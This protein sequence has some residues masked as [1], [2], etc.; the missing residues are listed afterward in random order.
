MADFFGFS[1]IHVTEFKNLLPK[2]DFTERD[3]LKIVSNPV[4]SSGKAA[5]APIEDFTNGLYLEGAKMN[6]FRMHPKNV[7]KWVELLVVRYHQQFGNSKQYECH[8]QNKEEDNSNL[9]D[10]IQ[11]Q[12]N[13]ISES[14]TLKL[15]T[16]KVYL[17]THT[18]TIQGNY[19]EQWCKNEFCWMKQLINSC[20]SDELSHEQ[21]KVDLTSIEDEF[22]G[23][24]NG[25]TLLKLPVSIEDEFGGDLNDTTLLKLPVQSANVICETITKDI[26]NDDTNNNVTAIQSNKNDKHE[27]L[28]S[29]SDTIKTIHTS[30]Q[31][32]ESQYCRFVDLETDIKSL[33]SK[34]NILSQQMEEMK[35]EMSTKTIKSQSEIDI[36]KTENETIKKRITQLESTIISK[37]ENTCKQ[38][39]SQN[40][41]CKQLTRKDEQY[42]ELL[43]RYDS[44]QQLNSEKEYQIQ[45]LTSHI[46][47]MEEQVFKTNGSLESIRIEN[48]KLHSELK[49]QKERYEDIIEKIS[50]TKI[51][52]PT[53]N[54]FKALAETKDD[55]QDSE[56]SGDR[57]QT[58]TDFESKTVLIISD[59]HGNNLKAEKMY[60]NNR[61]RVI[62]LGPG[63]KNIHGASEY[64]VENGSDI[65]SSTEIVLMVGSNDLER[66]TP[67]ANIEK[68]KDLIQI[69]KQNLPRNQI[70][71]MPAFIRLDNENYNKKLA[72]Y[73]LKL[74]SLEHEN[75][76]IIENKEITDCNCCRNLFDDGIHFSVKGTMA[77]VRILKSH[78]NVRLGLKPYSEYHKQNGASNGHQQQ[79][80]NIGRENQPRRFQQS[81]NRPQKGH[82]DLKAALGDIM[83]NL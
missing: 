7:L 60:K 3:R 55:Y 80:R 57:K 65:N 34:N 42:Q 5:D 72:V 23:D 59:S 83:R 20:S 70:H 27:V 14:D 61:A 56:V 52:I 43:K 6:S 37:G 13:S 78:L 15:F 4:P 36:L 25:T 79:Q 44:I 12:I 58:N 46:S 18:V 1:P 31:Q 26:V 45:Q 9:I 63:K 66:N 68:M 32:L 29:M 74:L 19:F 39:E 50:E 71:I 67:D 40:E 10:E 38:G 54:R 51:T 30:L 75:I 62:V 73:N 64:I 16:I 77:L 33:R 76:C 8:W 82:F 81:R 48:I 53:S 21:D 69:C 28:K 47:G 24:L 11:I 49:L 17:N 41:L 22:G 2:V 35:T